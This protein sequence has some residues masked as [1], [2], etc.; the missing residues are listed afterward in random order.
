MYLQFQVSIT[1]IF[2]GTLHN[3][4]KGFLQMDDLSAMLYALHWVFLWLFP[5]FLPIRNAKYNCII[6]QFSI[7]INNK[8][9]YFIKC[10]HH[11]IQIKIILLKISAISVSWTNSKYVL[12]TWM[13][14]PAT[15]E[16]F[17]WP[18]CQF[19]KP[20]FNTTTLNAIYLY[21]L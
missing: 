18:Q 1:S 14:G 8:F 10:K 11:K 7:M 12:T 19:I 20:P 6:K 4:S 13:I 3:L 5:T 17:H 15:S 21:T 2:V 16:T 9:R